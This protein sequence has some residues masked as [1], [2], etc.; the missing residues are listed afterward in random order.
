ME[1]LETED[2]SNDNGD[3]SKTEDKPAY[4]SDRNELLQVVETTQKFSLFSKDGPVF[5]SYANHVARTI[6]QPLAEKTRQR[7]IR[8][9]FQNL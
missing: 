3:A 2:V 1:M 7:T 4:C 8:D 6:D 5:Q 9:Y